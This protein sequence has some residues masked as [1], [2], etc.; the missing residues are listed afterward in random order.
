MALD[1]VPFMV[2]DAIHDVEAFQT[3]PYVLGGAKEGVAGHADLRVTATPTTPDA[4]VHV[5]AGAANLINQYDGGIALGYTVRNDADATIHINAQGAGGD[6]Y[7]LIAVVIEDPQ[8]PGQPDPAD[9][10]D[11]PF[12]FLRVYENIGDADTLAAVD[13]DQTG[14]A[15][16]RVHMPAS[17]AV[18]S[19]SQIEDIRELVNP[20]V[21]SVTR[22]VEYTTASAF[23]MPTTQGLFPTDA[24]WDV[25][26]PVW[27][28]RVRLEALWP[29]VSMLDSSG[30]G[31][32]VGAGSVVVALGS[33]ECDAPWVAAGA[34]AG[35]A[36]SQCLAVAGEAEVPEVLRGTVQSLTAEA[37]QTTVT[38]LVARLVQNSSGIV[39][40]TF[41]EVAGVN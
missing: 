28:N 32:G 3:L 11:G 27:A 1:A 31:T 26:I 18:V 5:A 13:A 2:K 6:R 37:A 17:T 19:N 21:F 33:I 41:F 30:A 24:S 34:V 38:N 9:T 39:K 12:V 35:K 22:Q 36:L 10:E 25:E 15:I 20:R 40:A 29:S 16:A 7:D 4:N 8:Y 23:V 14:Y